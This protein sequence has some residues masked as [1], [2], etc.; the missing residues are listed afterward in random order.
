M[1][2]NIV[3][4]ARR[5]L[6]LNSLFGG[7][8]VVGGSHIE[9]KANAVKSIKSADKKDV[10]I[11]ADRSTVYNNGYY[12]GF[13]KSGLSLS[14]V[15]F[16]LHKV[17]QRRML[18]ERDYVVSVDL[19]GNDDVKEIDLKDVLV[20]RRDFFPI[21]TL[22]PIFGY[23]IYGMASSISE[24]ANVNPANA[25]IAEPDKNESGL[26]SENAKLTLGA[27]SHAA[28]MTGLVVTHFAFNSQVRNR[29]S[30]LEYL[31]RNKDSNEDDD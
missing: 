9:G 6:V 24:S 17:A 18:S 29:V 1:I 8:A 13:A 16:L 21:A 12:K 27:S 19:D 28:G 11:P 7:M 23:G 3:N 2:S 25:A 5:R 4:L 26:I 10:A 30:L 14:L 31:D 20:D 15:L 22:P